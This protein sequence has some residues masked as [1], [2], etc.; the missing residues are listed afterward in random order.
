M[1]DRNISVRKRIDEIL[2]NK[3]WQADCVIHTF[4]KIIKY[5]SLTADEL[6]S[7]TAQSINS[8]IQSLENEYSL[9]ANPQYT[10]CLMKLKEIDLS[11]IANIV[12]KY[13]EQARHHDNTVYHFLAE[14]LEA[15]NNIWVI[16]YRERTS[17]ICFIYALSILLSI[18]ESMITRSCF[19][20]RM[21]IV[22]YVNDMVM[23]KAFVET[24]EPKEGDL[25]LYEN[26]SSYQHAGIY[27]G[28]NIVESKW[29]EIPYIW[30]HSLFAVP[31]A[32]GDHVRYFK[33]SDRA[34]AV[35]KFAQCDI[36]TNVL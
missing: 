24:Q 33:V 30:K 6:I 16:N 10:A 22:E 21:H 4:Y 8:R 27:R 5:E 1:F 25:V 2:E 19:L 36:Q 13:L 32:Y 31:T 18:S 7:K 20:A 14:E 12:N 11:F 17:S 34:E 35:R 28:E 9:N 29:G 23:S 26:Q 15:L 3:R